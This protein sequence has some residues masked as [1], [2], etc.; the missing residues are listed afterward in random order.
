MTGEFHP[1]EAQQVRLAGEQPAKKMNIATHLPRMAASAADRR[2]I[3]LSRRHRG[4]MQY[5][6][7]TFT[8]LEAISNRH[9]NGLASA[10]IERGHRVLLMV[11]QGFDFVSLVFALFKMRAVPVM[12]DPGMGA[13]RLLDCLRTVPLDALVGVPV[14]QAVRVLRP[15][16]FRGAKVFV[17]VGRRW[18]WG[19]PT[20]TR[21]ARSASD[22]FTIADTAGDETAAILFTSGS[23]GPAKGVVYE[24]GMFD[25]QVRMIQSCYG[26]EPGEIDL[27]TFPLFALFSVTMGMTI[28]LPDMDP[29]HP[30]RVNPANIVAAIRDQ[31]VTNT[32][33]SPAVWRR[34]AAYC[35]ERGITL[36]TLRRI[37]IAGA[38]VP[39]TVIEQLHQ[40]L[41]PDA[42]VHT[43][44]GATES[45][46]VSTISG[47]EIVA[48]SCGV[49]SASRP[50]PHGR[51]SEKATNSQD[52]TSRGLQSAR[53]HDSG[54][55]LEQGLSL[56]S[57]TCVGLPLPGVE[58]RIIRITDE[59]IVQWSGE[60]VIPDGEVGELCVRGQAVT[61]EYF[62]LPHAN[63]KSKIRDGDTTWH[64]IGDVGWRDV[65]GRLWF[66]GRKT[67]RVTTRHGT[68]FTECIEPLFNEHADVARSA[69]VGVGPPGDQQP[70]VIIEPRPGRFRRFKNVPRSGRDQSFIRELLV[71]VESNLSDSMGGPGITVDSP[72][73]NGEHEGVDASPLTKGGHRGVVERPESTENRPVPIPIGTCGSGFQPVEA[74]D[75]NS[76]STGFRQS[77]ILRSTIAD[78]QLQFLFHRSLPVDV[79]HNAKINR[80]AL[81]AWAEKSLRL[82]VQA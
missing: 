1:T 70:V 74:A 65:A 72:V 8:E 68:L 29:S 41:S 2:A 14:A 24:H 22:R 27:P 18:F 32:F 9:A 71:L 17:T 56:C 52:S 55:C 58:V 62:G 35:V 45:L 37:L 19:G 5:S 15:G 20:L 38:P 64:R 61:K 69:L 46:P 76:H 10:G 63:A 13:R 80:E 36:P 81:A 49:Q 48:A 77:A 75:R 11:R 67:H 7:I 78:R 79:R 44:Y 12:I 43:P 3:V 57:G 4:S 16:P 59:P 25:A 53:S 28:V 82:Q 66:C 6:S 34:V 54:K 42:D 51:G 50:L 40:V 39:R 47:R 60:L 26:I 21:L 23:T 73:A 33:G 31:E 30:G